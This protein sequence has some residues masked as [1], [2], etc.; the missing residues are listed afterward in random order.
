MTLLLLGNDVPW[1]QGGRTDSLILVALN[2]QD[3]AVKMLSIPRDL[4]VVIP[5]WRMTRI[6]L[7]LPHG[8][9]SGYPDGGGGL[10]KDTILYN[11]GIPVDYYV[12]IGFSGF[13]EIID[14]VGGV[15]IVT[16]C[17]IEDWRLKEPTLDPEIE[18][19]WESY[20][21][22][23]GIHRMDGETALWYVRSRK[24]SNDIDRGRRQQKMVRAILQQVQR[25]GM[26][27]N[28]PALWNN[29]S[30]MFETDLPLAT[31]LELAALAPQIDGFEHGLLN[32][33]A[34]QSWRIPESGEAVQLLN[35]E[36]A[37]PL[38]KQMLSKPALNKADRAPI[39]V[40]VE[41]NDP[42]M[43]RQVA[44]NLIWYGFEPRL[45]YREESDPA[46]T[47]ITYYGSNTKGAFL[48]R[49]A[50]VFRQD[51][52][53]IG[54]LNEGS[55]QKPGYHVD[56]GR[57]HDPCLPYLEL[58]KPEPLKPWPTGTPEREL[59]NSFSPE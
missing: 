46:Q 4:F 20:L 18:S 3:G 54:L 44:E 48:E 58:D 36:A 31:L 19:N 47:Q 1:A 24:D 49:L 42:F 50:A 59:D 37:E 53:E 39:V 45:R 8:H 14:G 56:L 23:P 27:L 13:K 11:L 57:G 28:L 40:E 16:N 6:N 17:P 5:G 51:G 32:G 38:L 12:R 9:G 25:N 41:T 29:F 2:R 33:E 7:A 22:P 26:Q 30:E 34:L 15:E 10:I 52:A 35:R 43:Y 21:L 55:A